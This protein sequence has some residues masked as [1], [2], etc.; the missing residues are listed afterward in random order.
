MSDEVTPIYAGPSNYYGGIVIKKDD[1]GLTWWAIQNYSG[2]TWKRCPAEVYASLAAFQ[3][4]Y[5]IADPHCDCIGHH[6]PGCWNDDEGNQSPVTADWKL[7][8]E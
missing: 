2:T 8:D 7:S 6:E 3:S 1:D 5:P 4:R